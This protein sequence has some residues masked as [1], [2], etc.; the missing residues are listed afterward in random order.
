[1]DPRQDPES[2]VLLEIRELKERIAE[3]LTELNDRRMRKYEASRRQLFER[4]D[5]PAMKELPSE[6]FVYGEWKNSKVNV[7]Y[8]IEYQR[9]F[10]SVRFRHVGDFVYLR[11]TATIRSA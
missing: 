2:N 9:H 3:L 7:D 4:I 8:H 6:P 10:Y 5:R 11:A 1:M